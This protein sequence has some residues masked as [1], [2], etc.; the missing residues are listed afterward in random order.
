MGSSYLI[1]GT[2]SGIGKKLSKLVTDKGDKVITVNRKY[3]DQQSNNQNFNLDITNFDEVFNLVNNLNSSSNIPDFF[4]LNAGV[5]MFDNNNFLSIDDFKK[6][7]DINFYGSMNFVSSIEKLSIKNVCFVF[8][9]STSNIVPNPAALGYFSSK[10][11]INKISK[12]LSKHNFYK[13]IILGPVKTNISRNTGQ[14][15]GIAKI[16]YKNL[17]IN[18]DKAC[19]KIYTFTKNKRKKLYYTKKSVIFYYMIKIILYVFPNLYKGGK[20]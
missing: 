20:N 10:Y 1:T 11:L 3:S 7:F 18:D 17:A 2:T 14:P 4:I 19:N 5:N 6:C 13:V 15:K 12:Y 9:S 8:M 16:I